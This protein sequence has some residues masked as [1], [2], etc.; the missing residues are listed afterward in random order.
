MIA[1]YRHKLSLP[2]KVQVNVRQ[3]SL[4]QR[5]NSGFTALLLANLSPYWKTNPIILN[6]FFWLY[7]CGSGSYQEPRGFC[8]RY[9]QISS[10]LFWKDSNDDFI[11]KLSTCWHKTSTAL[12]SCRRCDQIPNWLLGWC[13]ML[14]L[15]PDLVRVMEH[16]FSLSL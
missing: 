6:K 11:L 2:I 4:K 10:W 12:G 13:Q 8:R 9:D 3:L 1:L 16:V 15:V 14:Q 7:F 5:Q